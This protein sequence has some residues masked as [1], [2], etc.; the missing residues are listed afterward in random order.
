MGE[1]VTLMIPAYTSYQEGDGF[2]I[3]FDGGSGVVNFGDRMNG[4]REPMWPGAEMHAGFGL[5][6]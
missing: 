1:V 4:H 5:D 6:G 3:F 2:D